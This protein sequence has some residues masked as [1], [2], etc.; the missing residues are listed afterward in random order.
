MDQTLRLVVIAAAMVGILLFI[1]R[2]PREDRAGWRDPI[3][4]LGAPDGN[5]GAFLLGALALAQ[6][7][8]AGTAGAGVNVGT[9]AMVG[10][11]FALFIRRGWMR[12]LL[13]GVGLIAA[14]LAMWNYVKAAAPG[15]T[16]MEAMPFR[17]ALVGLVTACYTLGAGVGSMRIRSVR[18]FSFG[19]GRGLAFFG[20]IEVFIFLAQP[21]GLDL[22][23]LDPDSTLKF[24][25]IASLIAFIFGMITGQFTLYVMAACVALLAVFLPMAGVLADPRAG[26][27]PMYAVGGIVVYAIVRALAARFVDP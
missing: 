12:L 3:S 6:I 10:I 8:G 18:T 9:G 4:K 23:T 14:L 5:T 11:A 13:D 25:V 7:M 15:T 22:L 19:K 24:V 21:A 26:N 2:G 20:L 17:L 1:I 16:G 27:V